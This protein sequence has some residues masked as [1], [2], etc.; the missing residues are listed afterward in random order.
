MKPTDAD[1][2]PTIIILAAV[3]RADRPSP[4]IRPDVRAGPGKQTTPRSGDD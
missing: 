2:P 4:I 3:W 1:H